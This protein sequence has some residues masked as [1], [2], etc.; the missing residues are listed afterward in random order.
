MTDDDEQMIARLVQEGMLVKKVW[1]E[2]FP[3]YT[4]G[5][6]YWAAYGQGARSALGTQ[7]MISSRLNELETAGKK[8]RQELIGEISDLVWQQY[9]IITG[10]AAKLDRIR[11][12]LG[13]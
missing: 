10:N 1:K 12:T 5:D 2:R 13:E 9:K 11:K 6:V 8:K 4:Y 3:Q 7:R